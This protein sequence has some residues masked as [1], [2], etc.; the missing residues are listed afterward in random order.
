MCS[1]A[2]S[3][4]GTKVP[5]GSSD[6]QLR[7]VDASTGAAEFEVRHRGYVSWTLSS[8]AWSPSGTKVAT[9]S[10]VGLH[11]MDAATGAVEIELPSPNSPRIGAEEEEKVEV[12][13]WFVDSVAWSP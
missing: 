4:S 9:G 12:P 10:A 8:V 7:I 6:R 1:V 11:I 13:L 2:W 3:P 5:T